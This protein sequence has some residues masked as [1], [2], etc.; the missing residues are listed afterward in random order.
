MLG[1]EIDTRTEQIF[2]KISELTNLFENSIKKVKILL[3]NEDLTI[4]FLN[5]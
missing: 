2:E 4:L 1:Y 3:N 5:I